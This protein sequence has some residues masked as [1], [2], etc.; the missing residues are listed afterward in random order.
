MGSVVDKLLLLRKLTST[1]DLS[2]IPEERGI[3]NKGKSTNSFT[4]LKDTLLILLR[5]GLST[6]HS[7]LPHPE[8]DY[9]QHRSQGPFSS[10][11]SLGIRLCVLQS[12]QVV[13]F[14]FTT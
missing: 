8:R 4:S 6:K 12:S 9:F 3:A 7:F 1:T 5:H 2:T 13:S 11:S 10:S 14:T